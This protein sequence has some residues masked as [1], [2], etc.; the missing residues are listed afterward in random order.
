MSDTLFNTISVSLPKD[1]MSKTEGCTDRS[2]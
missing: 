2:S 1:T